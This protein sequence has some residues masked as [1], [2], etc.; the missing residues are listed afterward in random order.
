MIIPTKVE[1]PN[2]DDR[3]DDRYEIKT[4]NESNE[5]TRSPK[6]S[7]HYKN[8]FED[9]VCEGQPRVYVPTGR[10]KRGHNVP[11]VQSKTTVI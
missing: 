3:G 8:P 6:T 9:T 2:V 1:S 4:R 11:D 10:Y 7:L 5:E